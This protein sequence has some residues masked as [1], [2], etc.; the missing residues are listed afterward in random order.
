MAILQMTMFID[1]I[2]E[3]YF[4]DELPLCFFIS[5]FVE[6]ASGKM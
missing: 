3:W 4:F 6:I 2:I 5:F 1:T